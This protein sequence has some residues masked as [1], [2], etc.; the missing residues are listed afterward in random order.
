MKIKIINKLKPDKAILDA[1]SNNIEAYADYVKNKVKCEIL[2]EHK[3]DANYPVVGAAS[4]LAKVT[5]DREIE[6]IK[7]KVGKD[8]GS[9]YPSDPITQE[10]LKKNW[11]KYDFFRKSWETYKK[12]AKEKNQSKLGDF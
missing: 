8:I 4:I 1:P 9:G 2:A 12:I 5:R 11:N 7:E 3:A 6:K 10:F